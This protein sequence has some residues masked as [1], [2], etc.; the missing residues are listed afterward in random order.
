MKVNGVVVSVEIDVQVAKKDGGSYPG[1]RL[2]YRDDSGKLTEQAF[3]NN[4]FKFNAALKNS[5]QSLKPGD[6]IVIE[7][8]KK[9]DFWNVMGIT[10]AGE[11][12]GVVES[13]TKLV[14]SP[15]STYETPDERA[16]KQ[17]YIIRQSSVGHAV[18]LL[19]ANGGKKNT[20]KEVIEVAKTFENYV[21]TGTFDD[22]TLTGFEGDEKEV[23]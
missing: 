5:L 7:K 15:K 4:A 2:S 16:Q 18:E 14:A 11:G 1:S 13:T 12:G 10:I 20:P 22:G 3:H 9:G 6:K 23:F 17:V 21:L 19:A 8:E